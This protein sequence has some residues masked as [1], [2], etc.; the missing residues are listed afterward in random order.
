MI[1]M[2][3][4]KEEWINKVT[5]SIAHINRAEAPAFL[6]TRVEEQLNKRSEMFLHWPIISFSLA[7][8]ALLFVLNIVLLKDASYRKIDNG[9]Y[10]STTYSL[11][12]TDYN[13]Y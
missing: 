3:P 12:R 7:G 9:S 13:L 10:Q 6:F 5:D 2:K 11:N 4:S 1:N 8:L